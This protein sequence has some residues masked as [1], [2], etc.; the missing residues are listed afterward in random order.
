MRLDDA[1]RRR[2]FR[3]WYER[4]LYEGHAYLVT[5]LLALIM[6]AL[7]IEVIAFRQSF[8][9]LVALL[10]IGAAGGVVCVFAWRQF[11]FL[12][13]RAEYVAERATCPGCRAYAKFS[14]DRVDDVPDS[15]TGCTLHVHCRVCSH[16]W[17]ID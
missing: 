6:M 11:T 8:G 12:L 13:A 7:A 9:G 1:I 10:A 2:G 15:V 16:G 17:R 14:I 3:R 5:G 4:Q